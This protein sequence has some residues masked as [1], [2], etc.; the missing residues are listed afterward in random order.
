MCQYSAQLFSKFRKRNTNSQGYSR[1]NTGKQIKGT[2][3]LKD[4]QDSVN[5]IGRERK[6]AGD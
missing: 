5:T 3:H 4:L 2:T 6:K 1:N